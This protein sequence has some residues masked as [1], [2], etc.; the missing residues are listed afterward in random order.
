M[1]KYLL[2]VLL[3]FV[4][5][6]FGEIKSFRD[7]TKFPL[8]DGQQLQ[9]DLATEVSNRQTAD[10]EIKT[11]TGSN[12]SAIQSTYTALNT[13]INEVKIDTG[14]LRTDTDINTTNIAENYADIVALKVSTGTLVKKSGDTMTGDLTVPQVNVSTVNI[15]GQIELK[16]GTVITSTVTLGGTVDEGKFMQ[17]PATATLEMANYNLKNINGI[18]NNSVDYIKIYNYGSIP[19]PPSTYHKLYLQDYA[20]SMYKSLKLNFWNGTNYPGQLGFGTGSPMGVA[21]SDGDFN[22]SIAK[23][24]AGSITHFLKADVING[25]NISYMPFQT[26]SYIDAQGGIT[27]TIGSYIVMNDKELRG[28]DT[29]RPMAGGSPSLGTGNEYWSE[30]HIKRLFTKMPYSGY[31]AMEIGSDSTNWNERIIKLYSNT[32]FTYSTERMWIE[33]DGDIVTLSSITAGGNIDCSSVTVSG[34]VDNRDISKIIVSQSGTEQ[35]DWIISVGTGTLISANTTKEVNLTNITE[36]KSV[37]LTHNTTQQV[38]LYEVFNTS[39]TVRNLSLT[40]D[41]TAYWQVIAR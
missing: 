36:V 24:D 5:N 39:F 21:T 8:T 11:S 23:N 41:S 31:P 32:A 37:N 25:K 29:L 40:D 10:N 27:N 16:D 35:T 7:N 17:N 4:S 20:S 34:S 26:N 2:I 9:T 3:F 22:F 38:Y 28:L 30:C 1:K 13:K 15:S 18:F 33:K 6:L 12:Y 19:N 14:T